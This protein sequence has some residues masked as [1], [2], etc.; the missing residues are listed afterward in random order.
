[1]GRG[2]GTKLGSVA[3]DCPAIAGSDL[4][5]LGC[6][7]QG[8]PGV[9]R[10]EAIA[11]MGYEVKRTVLGHLDQVAFHLIEQQELWWRTRWAVV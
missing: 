8:D 11:T 9:H 1:L 6:Q 2:I 7:L 3:V 5:K 4:W 10:L